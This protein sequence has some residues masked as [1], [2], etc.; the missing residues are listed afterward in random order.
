MSINT[1]TTTTPFVVS[2]I[3]KLIISIKLAFRSLFFGKKWMV[4]T[5]LALT[6]LLLT[7]LATDK[8][9]GNDDA[10]AAYVDVFIG[11][12]LFLF[13]TFSC[14]LLS[15]PISGDEISDR[16]FELMI[17]RS[18]RRETL[19][20]SRWIVVHVSVFL[21][22]FGISII[23]YVYF[24]LV[25]PNANI[26][27]DLISD[28][29]L[30]EGTAIVILAGTLVYGGLFLTVAFIGRKGL[31]IGILLAIFE[32]FFLG[33]LFLDDEPY[34]PRTNLQVIA[35]KS[36]GPLYT[37]TPSNPLKTLPD[38]IFSWTYVIIVAAAFF[39][40][41]MMYLKYREFN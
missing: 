6:P 4:Y 33:I 22:N 12:I 23:Y 9:L 15:L 32:L 36:F 16:F 7:M 19:W 37:Y 41:G 11:S 35:D 10:K 17:V 40:I 14:L 24:H 13:F 26:I 34:I 3:E 39:L 25:D 31:S 20:L 2:E 18:I 30:L 1:P 5:I 21:V 8:L 27:D 28:L 38:V 29:H